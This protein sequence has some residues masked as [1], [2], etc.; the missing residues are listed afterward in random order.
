MCG[1]ETIDGCGALQPTN[2]KVDG[3]VGIF[4]HWKE[5]KENEKKELLDVEVIKQLFE[6][7]SDEDSKFMGFDP[8]WCR[9]EWLICSVLPVPPP[10][11]GPSVKQD[12]FENGR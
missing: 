2:Y 11:V 1:Q 10:A 6:R 8:S 9:P 3:V 12:N 7:I 4:A 5:D